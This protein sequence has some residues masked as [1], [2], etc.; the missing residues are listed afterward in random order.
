M[1]RIAEP[2]EWMTQIKAE[3]LH[4]VEQVKQISVILCLR[5]V[6]GLWVW[7]TEC[8]GTELSVE[9]DSWKSEVFCVYYCFKSLIGSVNKQCYLLNPGPMLHSVSDVGFNEYWSKMD[10]MLQLIMD[11]FKELKSE[12]STA[13][14]KC[15]GTCAE[16][17]FGLSAKWT[18][19][20][21]SAGGSVQSTTGSR[22]VWISGQQ[23]YYL[24]QVHWS[25]P[26]NVATRREEVGKM[27][28]WG[29]NSL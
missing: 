22:G 16:T 13:C 3:E 21:T 15:D 18:S 17:R 23:L 25:Q 19:P 10:A 6:S 29:W 27:E 20:F 7:S 1:G 5:P 9:S 28:W 4:S 11:Q 26:E 12:I 8:M 14:L 2:G 24:W